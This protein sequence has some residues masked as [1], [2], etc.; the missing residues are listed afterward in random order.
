[1]RLLKILR[2]HHPNFRWIRPFRKVTWQLWSTGSVERV[3]I[4]RCFNALP[5]SASSREDWRW[6]PRQDTSRLMMLRCW[7]HSPPLIHPMATAIYDSMW[8][9]TAVISTCNIAIGHYGSIA[10][11]H[12]LITAVDCHIL[13][14]SEEH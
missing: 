12:V 8:Q 3:A 7:S 9:S 10:I 2:L 6:V 1:M 5:I 13:S 14:R 4:L 11:L